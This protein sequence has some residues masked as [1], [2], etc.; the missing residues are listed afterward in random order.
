LGC[1]ASRR[2]CST[3]A[4][5]GRTRTRAYGSISG[6]IAP[7]T[8]KGGT[9]DVG[10][11]TH[12]E[13]KILAGDP[14]LHWVGTA[15]W[16]FGSLRSDRQRSDYSTP[17]K[18]VKSGRT[19]PP[20]PVTNRSD[21]ITRLRRVNCKASAYASGGHRTRH[22]RS[23]KARGH[24]PSQLSHYRRHRRLRVGWQPTLP[25]LPGTRWLLHGNPVVL[26]VRLPVTCSRRGVCDR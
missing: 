19:S 5:A 10:I 8:P 15:I 2:K 22:G 25:W 9:W 12:V 17:S 26:A 24:G 14:R 4:H 7:V 1:S 18:Q 6:F 13:P 20:T 11:H 23:T 3:L 21:M 16:M